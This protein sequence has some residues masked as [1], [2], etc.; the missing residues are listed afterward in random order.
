MSTLFIVEQYDAQ[1]QA[2]CDV[3]GWLVL[4][5]DADHAIRLVEA[6]SDVLEG[7][8][9]GLRADPAEWTRDRPNDG[10]LPLVSRETIHYGIW[11]PSDTVM[12]GYGFVPSDDWEYCGGCG[13][14]RDTETEWTKGGDDCDE[15]EAT[16]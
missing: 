16:P 10:P 6:D 8:A 11:R 12:A 7:E 2:V 3:R 4:A 1:G 9:V 14:V 13:I 15:C 5:R